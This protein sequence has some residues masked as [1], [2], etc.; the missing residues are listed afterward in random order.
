MDTRDQLL[1]AAVRAIQAKGLARVRTRDITREAGCAE[2]TLYHHFV[3]KDDLF[4]AVIAAH[5]PSWQAVTS[6]THTSQ[7]SVAANLGAIAGAALRF[8]H[9]GVTLLGALFADPLLLARYREAVTGGDGG[10]EQA[11]AAVVAYLQSEQ[12]AGRVRRTA[13]PLAVTSLL[14][15]ACFQHAFVCAFRGTPPDPADDERVIAQLVQTLLP[16][17][18]PTDDHAMR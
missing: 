2:G 6:P 5:W 8:Y 7:A 11:S 14:L 18:L 15:G 16:A 12:A 1:T 10:P 3:D 13:D 9:A 4:L 17:L